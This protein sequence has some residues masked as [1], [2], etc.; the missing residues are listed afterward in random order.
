VPLVPPKKPVRTKPTPNAPK[1]DSARPPRP[2]KKI[3]EAR[4]APTLQGP[5]APQPVD[6]I[7]A[8]QAPAPIQQPR[9]PEPRNKPAVSASPFSAGIFEGMESDSN[10]Y[11][12]AI[13]DETAHNDEMIAVDDQKIG[14]EPSEVW[15]PPVKPLTVTV[16][17]TPK[18]RENSPPP[19]SATPKS[20]ENGPPPVSGRRGDLLDFAGG[21]DVEVPEAPLPSVTGSPMQDRRPRGRDDGEAGNDQR[22]RRRGRGQWR[23]R[24]AEPRTEKEVPAPR[25]RETPRL[26]PLPEPEDR[27]DR[28]AIIEDE[29]SV[30]MSARPMDLPG[31]DIEFTTPE[32][33]EE[34]DEIAHGRE[35]LD[36]DAGIDDEASESREPT[37]S[38]EMLI[39]VADADECRIAILREGRLDELYMERAASISNVGN[40]YKG[41]VTNVEPSIQ[42]AFVD[43]GKPTHGFL[44]IS[45]LHPRYFPES[46]GEPELVGRKTPR[47]QR[48][49]IQVC[50]RRGQEVIVQ[51]IKEGIGTKGPTLSTYISL[52]GR[53]LVMMPGMDQLGVSRKIE[54][55]E[56]RRRMRDVLSELSLP[57]DMGFIVRTAGV[58]R[59]KRDLQRDLNYLARLWATVAKRTREE[60]APAELYKE[61]DLVIRT[62][63][64]V[65]DASLKRVIVDNSAVAARVREFLS[66]AS[67]N[68]E[69]VVVEYAESEP[70]FHRFGVEVEID[71]LHSRVVPLP[72]GGSLVIEQTEALVAIDVNSGRFRVP[73][74]AE[75]TAYRVN[76][77]AADEIARQLRLRDLGGLIICDFIDMMQEKHRRTIERRLADS[78]RKHKERAKLL[79]ISRF[80][81]LEMT[82]QRQRPSF[83]KSM[84]QECPRCSGSGRIKAT[85]SVCLD[86]MRQIRL[87]S[88]RDGVASVDVRVSS[89]VATELLN[90]K[91]HQ[92]TD[93][94]R[95]TGQTIRIHGD[96]NSGVDEVHLACID[97]RGR[98]VSIGPATP[99]VSQPPAPGRAPQSRSNEGRPDNGGPRPSRGHSRGR[100][101]R[102]GRG[103][104]QAGPPPEAR[105]GGRGGQGGP[106]PEARGGGRQDRPAGPKGGGGRGR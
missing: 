99:A 36:P 25:I 100:G 101:G 37:E 88:Q 19:V 78:L 96:P 54:D 11:D 44:H 65:Y 79:R 71:K 13:E 28:S 23:D 63:R 98:D 92:L 32:L 104:Q 6:F 73:E 60:P 51:V 86:V 66:I 47:R 45:D 85:E 20:R 12:V 80:G 26:E 72:S 50:L 30:R 70:M 57:K 89:A 61:S 76:V 27:I 7:D 15:H 18:S 9:P 17:A 42:A 5:I 35:I 43:F 52:P 59:S 68:V 21:L 1:K 29:D 74:N 77:E 95:E 16:S 8:P 34:I 91:R 41:R 22:G 84:F 94:E 2:R 83:A 55:E 53:F 49:P 4:G 90:R 39:N 56:T 40:I 31:E 33:D 87:A 14:I 93:L 64:D 38:R 3:G 81:I 103:G 10:A 58:D 24:D 46:R 69:D 67:P 106:P 62:I 75:E 82:R 102:G 105:G 48:P 97:R